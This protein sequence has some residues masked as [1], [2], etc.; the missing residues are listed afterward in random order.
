V[1]KLSPVRALERAYSTPRISGVFQ[2]R[3]WPPSTAMNWP[4]TPG[5][6]RKNPSAAVMSEGFAPRPSTVAARWRAKCS[7]LAGA[8]QGGAGADGVDADMRGKALRGRSGSG[9]KGP[10]WRWYRSENS[11]VSFRMR[12]SIMLTIRPWARGSPLW[13]VVAGGHWGRRPGSAHRA[14]AGSIRCGGPSFVAVA[15]SI[16]S[17]SKIE[18]LL[19]STVSGP[20]AA[21]TRGSA[22]DLRLVQKVGVKCLRAAAHGADFGG[23][24]IPPRPC[25]RRSGSRRHGRALPDTAPSRGPAACRPR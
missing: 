15:V 20:S 21:V 9:P 5:L 17:Y 1:D 14:R 4:V 24:G 11:G 2:P 12:W 23:H 19:T 3:C 7:G 6:S 18:A 13:S 16:R 8:D 25:W 22:P 10:S